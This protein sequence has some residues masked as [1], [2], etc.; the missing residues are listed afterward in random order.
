MD[1][2]FYREF[3]QKLSPRGGDLEL[4]VCELYTSV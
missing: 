4:C 1:G 3:E 2:C